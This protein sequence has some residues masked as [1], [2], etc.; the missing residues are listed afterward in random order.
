[1][2]RVTRI[3]KP[4][5]LKIKSIQITAKGVSAFCSVGFFALDSTLINGFHF[6]QLDFGAP[7][8]AT[9]ET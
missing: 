5:N 6:P 3:T 4:T 8:F 2:T 9:N 1:V 7:I